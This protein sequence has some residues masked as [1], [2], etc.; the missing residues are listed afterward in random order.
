MGDPLGV[1]NMT[2]PRVDSGSLFHF[3]DHCGIENCWTFVRIYHA[4]NGR[5]VSYLANC[6]RRQDTTLWDRSDRYP[7]PYPDYS[8]TPDSNPGWLSV[9]ILALTE[10]CALWVILLLLLLLFIYLLLL[11]LLLLL[12]LANGSFFISSQYIKT[13]SSITLPATCVQ[14]PM[15]NGL[16]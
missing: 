13:L 1:I 5:F 15:L 16:L 12:I 14:C 2:D 11:L 8:E 10:V 4:I 6:W 9:E 7:D 3:L